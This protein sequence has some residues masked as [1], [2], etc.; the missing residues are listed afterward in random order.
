MADDKEFN[1]FRKAVIAEINKQA[2]RIQ[3]LEK[4][5][6]TLEKDLNKEIKKTK[7]HS[8]GLISKLSRLVDD[9]R[10]NQVI[11]RQ[12]AND[13]DRTVQALTRRK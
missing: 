2:K 1:D 5:V 8:T 9:I 13:I 3:V 7:D 6:E 11:D 10:R 4:Q 12:K